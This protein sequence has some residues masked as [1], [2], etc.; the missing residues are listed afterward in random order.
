MAN[1]ERPG[2]PVEKQNINPFSGKGS[3][4]FGPFIWTLLPA[5][6]VNLIVYAMIRGGLIPARA[7]LDKEKALIF[8]LIWFGLSMLGFTVIANTFI[9]RW[10][11]IL[12][13]PALSS[14]LRS[15]IRFCLLSPLIAFPMTLATLAF[16]PGSPF[17]DVPDGGSK[18]GALGF[19]GGV[20]AISIVVCLFLPNSFFGL[21]RA[22]FRDST[23][24]F[25]NGNFNAG[26][27]PFPSEAVMKPALA[28]ATP[29]FRYLAWIGCDFIRTRM[30][31]SAIE[32][33]F[34]T[35]CAEK[36]GFLH[37]EVKDCYFKHLRNMA[38]KAPMV[39]PYFAL[40]FETEYRR[41]ANEARSAESRIPMD[42]FADS[43]LMISNM[44]ELLEPGPMFIERTHLLR[45][46]ILLHAFASPEF[47]LVEAG[48]DVQR[49]T[50]IEKILP[51]ISMQTEAIEV[52]LK[53]V[54]QI[55]GPDEVSVRSELRDIQIRVQA[56]QKDP[57]MIG[58]AE[59]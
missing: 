4:T 36:M 23:S 58:S 39:S 43:L 20:I 54:G 9:K 29:A 19:L 55:V 30:L 40:Y 28:A 5:V 11:D 53:S 44:V 35:L 59:H 42:R 26:K 12:G 27:N 7:I 34:A 1:M 22:G 18:S 52:A 17:V 38:T 48:Q 10:A 49:I 16:F 50:M 25:V 46:S 8:Y 3:L 33:N 14:T 13:E 45:P 31:S 2:K 21:E 41:A 15:I 37:V 56:I 6:V 47:P 32:T 57:L 51:V 24:E